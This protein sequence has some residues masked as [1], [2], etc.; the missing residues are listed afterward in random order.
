VTQYLGDYFWQRQEP[1]APGLPVMSVTMNDSLVLRD[2]LELRVTSALK[3]EQHLLVRTGDIAYNMMRMWQGACGLALADGIISP[4]YVVLVPKSG[5]DSRFAYHWFKSARMIYLFWAYSHG[6]T[7]DRLRLYFDEF[8]SI[9]ASPPPLEQQRRIINVLDCWDRAIHLLER[10]RDAHLERRTWFRSQLLSGRKRLNGSSGKWPELHLHEIL[11]EH[12]LH[13]LGCEQVFSVSVTKGLVNQ[14][15]HLGR[16]F[17]AKKTAHYNRVLPGDLVYTKSPTGDFPF[18]I[19]KQSTLEKEVIVSPLYGV[20]S[21]SSRALGVIIDAYFESPIATKNYLNPL[22]Q[23]GAKNTLAI[24]NKRFLEGKL[25]LPI[26]P[27]EQK[28][29]AA[30]LGISKAEILRIEG[31]IEALRNQKIGL[32]QKLFSGEWQLDGRFE[33][34][35]LPI[36]RG[37]PEPSSDAVLSSD[38]RKTLQ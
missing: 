19:L 29:L 27:E 18:G 37:G 5:I 17:A 38:R 16:S 9:P 24:T 22:V 10:L 3:S 25:K 15:E 8:A 36:G 31:Q 4:A 20:F 13:S 33:S 23:K 30:L 32:T 14:T 21:P 6:L 2:D 26:D 34:S 28:E 1:G 12:G 11:K 7:E 35:I